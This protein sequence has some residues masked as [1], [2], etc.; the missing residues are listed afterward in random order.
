MKLITGALVAA[1]SCL[2]AGFSGPIFAAGAPP[3][4][5]LVL[6]PHAAPGQD[7]YIGVTMTIQAP[8][9]QAGSPLVRLPLTLVGIPGARYDGNALTAHDDAGSLPLTL[10]QEPATV[11][12]VYRCWSV[13]RATK[14]DVVLTFKAPPRVV[15]SSTNNGPL[16]DLREENGGFE[17][18]GV[19]FMV[20]PVAEGPYKVHLKWDLSDMP[21]GSKGV[22]S[23]G[24]GEVTA[25]VPSDVLSFSYYAAGP[26]KSLPVSPDARLNVYWLNDPPFDAQALGQWVSRFYDYTSHFFG[27]AKSSYRVFMR[28]N[29]YVGLGGTALAHSFMFGYYPP[30]KPTLSSLRDLL[31]HEMTH[32]WPSLQGTHGDTAWYTEG[33]AEYYSLLF[34]YRAGLLTTDEY[35]QR[36]NDRAAGYYTSPSRNMPMAAVAKLYWK[37]PTMQR[38]PYGRGF[39]YLAQTDA[40]IRAKSGGKHSLD[41][42][43]LELYRRSQRNEP[44]G[45]AQWLDLVGKEL[46]PAEAKQA[47]DAMTSGQTLMIPPS[48]HAPCFKVVSQPHRI[49]EMGFVR[50]TPNSDAVVSELKP[51]SA[52]AR[53][54]VRNGDQIIRSPDTTKA[55]FDDSAEISV[56]LERNGKKF[57]ATYIPRGAMV[58]AYH[59]ERQP[60]VDSAA[61][62]F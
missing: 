43:V 61:C 52:A 41:D 39:L 18:A 13:A 42:I 38:D 36:I 4:V 12:G 14:G 29:P 24:D 46:G 48:S 58:D 56:E 11:E 37:D 34:A 22:W 57:T 59:W 49:F 25:I 35:L 40:A 15:T 21:A 30:A 28:Q 19:S 8:N 16:F 33:T 53:A 27:D 55:R 45:V 17:G 7:G 44:Y 51:D 50:S 5:T 6:K 3:A 62:K 2:A 9:L 26:L 23:L 1:V 10:S 31:S 32:T 47:F 54:G 60:G 20:T